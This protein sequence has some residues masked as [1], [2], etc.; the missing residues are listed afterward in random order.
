[1][2]FSVVSFLALAFHTVLLCVS[3]FVPLYS[4]LQGLY[5]L[6]YGL[7]LLPFGLY[8]LMNELYKLYGMYGLL[9]GLYGS[10]GFYLLYKLLHGLYGFWKRPSVRTSVIEEICEPSYPNLIHMPEVVMRK[11]LK[12]LDTKSMSLRKQNMD[13]NN[14]KPRTRCVLRWKEGCFFKNPIPVKEAQSLLKNTKLT[15]DEL[16]IDL[17]SSVEYNTEYIEKQEEDIKKFY[18]SMKT[19]FKNESHLLKIKKVRLEVQNL[20]QAIDLSECID[21]K[22]FKSVSVQFREWLSVSEAWEQ[23]ENEQFFWTPHHTLPSFKRLDGFIS[24]SGREDLDSKSLNTDAIQSMEWR[25]RLEEQEHIRS[26][27]YISFAKV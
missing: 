20:T 2:G 22:S 11:V 12:N 10:R 24:F 19:L 8:R 16:K 1:M 7:Y 25:S 6:L 5:G 18:E 21:S 15:L 14:P 17:C 9:Y 27:N 13:L 4:L 23:W 26:K 3:L